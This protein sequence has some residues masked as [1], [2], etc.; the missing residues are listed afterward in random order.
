MYE[1]AWYHANARIGTYE[2]CCFRHTLTFP[3]HFAIDEATSMESA[4]ITPV[5]EK[6]DPNFPSESP[7]FCLKKNVTHD[8][9]RRDCQHYFLFA[10]LGLL[11]CHSQWC[12]PRCE[13]VKCKQYAQLQQHDL[14]LLANFREKSKTPCFLALV[15]VIGLLNSSIHASVPK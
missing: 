7:N 9:C 15:V 11:L 8:L 14:A 2:Y 12:Q 13:I 1:E 10:G 6:I 3:I 5:M 4:D